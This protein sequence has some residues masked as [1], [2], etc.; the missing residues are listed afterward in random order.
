MATQLDGNEL[1]PFAKDNGNGAFLLSLLKAFVREGLATQTTVDGK[2][3]R[4]KA[5][6]GISISPDNTI[7]TT[8]DVSLFKIVDVLPTAN[9]E[10]KIYLV[11]DSNG[12]EGANEYIEYLYILGKWEIV[13]KY[14]ATV[15]L[16]PYILKED[17]ELLYA[18]KTDI[19]DVSGFADL[20]A[21]NRLANRLATLEKELQSAKTKLSTIPT[22]PLEDGK[23]YAIKSGAWV[24]IADVTESV[25]TMTNDPDE[26]TQNEPASVQ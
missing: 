24:E 4:L 2:Q 17:A 14:T 6:H 5:G 15:D 7:S 12:K 21:V 18:K 20:Q 19:P 22:M 3:N 23:C 8:L 9:I 13:G 25:A 1:L 11:P 10:N 26:E 16:S